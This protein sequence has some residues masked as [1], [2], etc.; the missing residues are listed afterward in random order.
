MQV[1]DVLNLLDQW[2][3]LAYSEE[4]DNTGLLVG[5]PNA[6]V[7]GIMVCLDALESVVQ[8]AIDKDCNLIV[9]FHP[10]IFSGLKSLSPND[11]VTRSVTKAVIHDIA[12][13][14]VHT[15]LDNLPTGVS[16]T[17]AKVLGLQ[18]TQ[19]LL[20]K[21]GV[22]HKLV[23]YAPSKVADQVREALFSAGAGALGLYEQCSFNTEGLG[24]FFP[25]DGAKPA[26]GETGQRH[27]E[28]ET[29]IQVSFLSHQ[30]SAVLKALETV[31]P[32]QEVAFDLIELSQGCPEVGMGLIGDLPKSI[33]VDGLLA[34]LKKDFNCGS[35]KHSANNGQQISK[36]AVLG[37]SGSFAIDRAKQLGAQA[38]I[39]AD[40]KYHDFFKASEDFILMDIG[41]YESE[42][43]TKDLIVEYL[44]KKITNF[45]PALTT[46]KV[47]KS[48]VKTNPISYY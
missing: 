3:P 44:S 38:Y 6:E 30:K 22:M 47:L 20:P 1:A 45:A 32:Y 7:T 2:A 19:V 14:S 35:I 12:I 46:I 15:A 17:M 43:F 33:S 21:T 31:H 13:I 8:E 29:Q 11:H 10:I 27:T 23:T 41:H 9:S 37:G 28:P 25:K 36:I 4:F 18:N 42:Q 26:V 24:T 5:S 39:T 34:Q 40:L 16:G 48:N